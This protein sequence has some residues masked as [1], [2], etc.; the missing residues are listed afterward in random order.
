MS[1]TEAAS[2]TLIWEHGYVYCHR[3]TKKKNVPFAT[4]VKYSREASSL[5]AYKVEPGWCLLQEE[6]EDAATRLG[7]AMAADLKAAG[8]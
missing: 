4:H 5:K 3:E 1:V 8:F 2:N 7:E 6:L